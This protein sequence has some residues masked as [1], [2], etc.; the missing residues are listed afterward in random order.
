MQE[1]ERIYYRITQAL[2]RVRVYNNLRA[3]G[4]GNCS[5]GQNSTEI[6][7]KKNGLMK[8]VVKSQRNL[9]L[10]HSMVG[11]TGHPKV[12]EQTAFLRLFSCLSA[13]RPQLDQL[14]GR[15]S[16]RLFFFMGK[17]LL[18][19]DPTIQNVSFYPE[20]QI[21]PILLIKKYNIEKS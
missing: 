12:S 1:S 14:L 5:C 19:G 2:S 4:R 16:S 6:T 9:R 15:D 18:G 10:T 17:P 11:F 8:R 7:M 3:R 20:P 21:G 13:R